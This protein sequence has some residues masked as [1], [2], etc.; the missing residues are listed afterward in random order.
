[1]SKGLDGLLGGGRLRAEF[2]PIVEL[3]SGRTVAF[4]AL[5]R[6]P[7]GSAIEHPRDLFDAAR[8]A[9]V[10]PDLDWECR[11]VA[12]AAAFAAGLAPPL[13]LFVNA[14]PASLST[15]CPPHLVS[16]RDQA[17]ANLRVVVEVTERALVADPAALLGFIG[18]ARRAG[19]GI[20]LDDVGADPASLAL[21]PLVQPDVIKLDLRLV[22][23]HPSP[24]VAAIV[25]AVAA[26]AEATGA[27]VLAEGVETDE[28]LERA[29]ALGATLGQ[30]W[31]FG[32]PGPLPDDAAHPG[33]GLAFLPAPGTPAASAVTALGEN[34]RW[35]RTTKGLLGPMSGHLEDYAYRSAEPPVLLACFQRADRFPAGVA[36]RYAELARWCSFVAA[37]GTDLPAE[38]APGVRGAHI[39]PDDP[40]AGEWVVAVV[41]PHFAAAIVARDLGDSGPELERRFDYVLTHDRDLVVRVARTLMGRVSPVS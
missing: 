21:M 30:G 20:A 15:P 27:A 41:G 34:I 38:P 14:E 6:G 12:V 28:Q 1:M 31:R 5:A 3:I 25:H 23:D 18:S 39:A 24:E 7:E 17:A 9:G 37:I 11:G 22:R 32:R 4:E 40:M 13:T 33:A 26:H 8:R 19:F 10:E 36:K 29:L 16:L 35:R 2:Q